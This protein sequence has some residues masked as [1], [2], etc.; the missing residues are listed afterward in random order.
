MG[1]A[2]SGLR[3]T[4]LPAGVFAEADDASLPALALLISKCPGWLTGLPGRGVDFSFAA[5]TSE[6]TAPF[7]A[8]GFRRSQCLDHAA[9]ARVA[10]SADTNRP[11]RSAPPRKLGV[12]LPRARNDRLAFGNDLLKSSDG[13]GSSAC[14]SAVHWAAGLFS[15]GRDLAVKTLADTSCHR[16]F[17]VDSIFGTSPALGVGV[18]WGTVLVPVASRQLACPGRPLAKTLPLR[19][20]PC[21]KSA[22]QVRR[23]PAPRNKL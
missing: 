10:I 4:V 12:K 13:I 9:P 20:T 21:P 3:N 19:K 1:S 23:T 16:P 15:I 2:G 22:G 11:R 18:S 6:P 5:T 8:S 14:S 17:A 7:C